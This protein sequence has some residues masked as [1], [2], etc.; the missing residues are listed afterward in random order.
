MITNPSLVVLVGP[1]ASGKS[2]WAGEHFT[3]QQ[4]VCADALRGIVGEHDLDLAASDDAFDILDQIVEMRLG[5]GLTTVVDTMGLNP[6][7]RRGYL[8]AARRHGVNAVAVPFATSATECKRRNRERAHPVPV[9]IID[10]MARKF[11]E[12]AP[13]LTEEGWDE[14]IAPEASSTAP[15]KDLDTAKQ[16]ADAPPQN[17]HLRFGLHVSNFEWIDDKATAGPKLAELAARAEAAGFDSIWLMDHLI[18][19]PQLGREWDTMLEP[20]TTLSYIAAATERIRL[21]VLVTP[22]TTRH[23]G[24]VAKLIATLDLLSGG[25]AIAGLGA[26]SSKAEH[27]LYGI[28]FASPT[29]RLDLLEETLQALPVIWGSGAKPFEG[30]TISIERAV[31]YPRPLQDPM[32][33]IVGG[34][35]EQRT[36]KIAAEHGSGCNLFGDL[37]A[38]ERRV[39]VVRGYLA[40]AGRDKADFEIT[41]LGGALLAADR[42]TLRQL[43][44]AERPSNVGPDRFAKR[45]NAG[46]LADHESRFRTMAEL[47]VDS[48]IINPTRPGDQA[49]FD[50]WAELISRFAGES[51][52]RH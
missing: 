31:G 28:P 3:A 41:H 11:R 47:G 42:N 40:A 50:V 26:A 20:Y 52:L 6:D 39:G 17:P 46:T 34:S 10:S 43:V 5:R 8:D 12:I 35:G 32:P 15:V 9:R 48:A 1:P 29:D 18:Q 25:R 19:I 33:I 21:G 16:Q 27:D 38:I 36:L 14:V 23:V 44:E 24:V 4:V 51:P 30:K 22:V 49:T 7:R 37:S 13:Q 2:S 45:A